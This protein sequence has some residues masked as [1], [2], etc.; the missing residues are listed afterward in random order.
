MAWSWCLLAPKCLYEL[1]TTT[2]F[3]Y[4]C[5]SRTFWRIWDHFKTVKWSWLKATRRF[6][7]VKPQDFENPLEEV[8]DLNYGYFIDFQRNPRSKRLGKNHRPLFVAWQIS[9]LKVG[10]KAIRQLKWLPGHRNTPPQ[11]FL[12]YRVHKRFW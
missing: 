1:L 2:S 4:T 5:S 9:A 11:I 12:S 7:M 8:I 3:T 6:Q 10:K